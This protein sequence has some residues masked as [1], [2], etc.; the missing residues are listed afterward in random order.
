MS[1]AE[2]LIN[3]ENIPNG[4]DANE[5]LMKKAKIES[6]SSTVL[7]GRKKHDNSSNEGIRISVDAG[8]D[9]GTEVS[10]V[11]ALRGWL[12]DFGKQHKEQ[13][14]NKKHGIR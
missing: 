13:S 14:M 11:S 4:I 6:T 8:S 7:S 2:R 10:S 9:C 12:D 3:D 1:S 5:R